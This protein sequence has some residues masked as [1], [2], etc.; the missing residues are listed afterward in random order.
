MKVFI[1]Q[2]KG[3]ENLIEEFKK[4]GVEIVSILDKKVTLIV[5]LVDEELWFFSHAKDW[6]K[7]QGITIAISNEFVVSTCRD[8]A[9]FYRFCKRHGF[10]TPLTMQDEI[11][12][13]PRF[14]KGSRGQF[15]IDRSYIVQEIVDWPEYSIDYYKDDNI[16]SIIPRLRLDVINGESKSC[17]IVEDKKLIDEAARLGKEL[18]LKYHNVM[19]CFYNGSDIKWIEVNPRYGG[20]SWM[21]FK[22]FNSPQHL[23]NSL[24]EKVK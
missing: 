17:K 6:F 4:T 18:D 23:I 7:E 14:G 3:K 24:G 21:T 8:K 5:P 10:N 9:E 16:L 22:K 12:A 11:I 13:K 19:Q 1:T 15:K 2:P 20:G